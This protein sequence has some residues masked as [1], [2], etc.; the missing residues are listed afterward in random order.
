MFTCSAKYTVFPQLPQLG[1]LPPNC[2]PVGIGAIGEAMRPFKA[3]PYRVPV[4]VEPS[5]KATRPLNIGVL[6]LDVDEE[7]AFVTTEDV[8]FS[9]LGVRGGPVIADS[10]GTVRGNPLNPVP[11][12]DGV[13]VIVGALQSS[14]SS[15]SSLPPLSFPSV[16]AGSLGGDDVLGDPLNDVRLGLHECVGLNIGAGEAA[17]AP[18]YRL[19]G[20]VLRAGNGGAVLRGE[21]CGR[22]LVARMGEVG[23]ERS[24]SSWSG[25]LAWRRSRVPKFLT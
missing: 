13:T 10:G 8:F 5:G 19:R 15:F 1:L 12:R 23:G 20:G 4:G 22:E 9:G 21:V 7:G 6:V 14:S 11:A 17:R 2:R 24:T 3:V 25:R 18:L 16:S